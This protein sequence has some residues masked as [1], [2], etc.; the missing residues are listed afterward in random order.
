MIFHIMSYLLYL[1]RRTNQVLIMIFLILE[2]LS[3]KAL[4]FFFLKVSCKF[5]QKLQ[6]CKINEQKRRLNDK[7]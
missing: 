6:K 1:L 2:L 3:E 5:P 4:F 7:V